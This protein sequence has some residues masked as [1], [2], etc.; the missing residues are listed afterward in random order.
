MFWWILTAIMLFILCA[1]LLTAEF[2]IP[3]FGLIT[4]LA[5]SCLAAGIAMFFKISQKAGW[6]GII[7]ACIIIPIVFAIGF[8]IFPKTS[9]GKALTLEGPKK[10]PGEGVPDAE[11]LSSFLGKTATAVSPLRPV[12]MCDFAGK[13]LECVAESGYIEKGKTVQVVK[14]EGTQLTVRLVDA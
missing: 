12:G 5:L 7:T 10:K 3:S 2:F 1:M 9:F 14:V 13:R 6:T 4:V 8:K 11:T